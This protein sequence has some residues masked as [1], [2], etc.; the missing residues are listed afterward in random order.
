M[1]LKKLIGV[2]LATVFCLTSSV[3]AFAAG[4]SADEQLL[5]DKLKAGVE[6]DGTVVQAPAEFLAQAENELKTNDN[7]KNSIDTLRK[8]IN[9]QG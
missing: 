4:I 8:K 7:L 3:T 9:P 6:V 5:L 1:K 2:A